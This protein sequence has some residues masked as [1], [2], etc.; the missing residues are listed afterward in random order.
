MSCPFSA[1]LILL[2]KLVCG[3][4]TVSHEAWHSSPALNSAQE[5]TTEGMGPNIC[6]NAFLC[7][8]SD[9]TSKMGWEP[10]WNL[11]A[12]ISRNTLGYSLTQ[13]WHHQPLRAESLVGKWKSRAHVNGS[14][15]PQA[16]RFFRLQCAFLKM[17]L[18]SVRQNHAICHSEPLII[19]AVSKCQSEIDLVSMMWT[20]LLGC[21]ND[22][23]KA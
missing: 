21:L 17:L 19:S 23:P 13:Q 12:D 3:L 20:A 8:I 11:G 9:V 6:E 22:T 5:P 1:S 14:S 15:S 4:Y 7:H 2:Q 16:A 18:S 10:G